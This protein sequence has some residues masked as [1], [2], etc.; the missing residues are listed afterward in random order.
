[1]P[2]LL[3]IRPAYHRR[4]L[5][6]LGEV[7]QELER[8]NRQ[9]DSPDWENAIRFIPHETTAY[10]GGPQQALPFRRGWKKDT[11]PLRESPVGQEGS[12]WKIG[13]AYP[14]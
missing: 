8:I 6:G 10:G 3:L 1:M 4:R 9:T 12:V 13:S 2:G 7:I 5:A 11:L 14:T